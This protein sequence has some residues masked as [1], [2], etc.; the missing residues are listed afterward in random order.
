MSKYIIV[1]FFIFFVVL[2]SARKKEQY[3]QHQN[4]VNS[5]EVQIRG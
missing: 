4:D 3:D 5:F 2:S 1:L